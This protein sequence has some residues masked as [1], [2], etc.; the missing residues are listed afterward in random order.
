MNLVIQFMISKIIKM[1]TISIVITATTFI[2]HNIDQDNYKDPRKLYHKITQSLIDIKINLAT[3]IDLKKSINQYPTNKEQEEENKNAKN[4]LDNIV[5]QKNL[6]KNLNIAK[7]SLA[8]IQNHLAS[9]NNNN[10]NQTITVKNN[11]PI[12][13]LETLGNQGSATAQF[14][15][16]LLYQYGILVPKDKSKAVAW[17]Q[18]AANQGDTNAKEKLKTLRPN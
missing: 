11:S 17:Y 3:V 13:F 1:F 8:N 14:I 4:L 6:Q 2:A 5:D 12:L 10:D 16:G 15:L 9:T 18:K 7:E